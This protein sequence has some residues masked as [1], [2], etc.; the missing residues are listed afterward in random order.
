MRHAFRWCLGA[1][2]M[3]LGY[4]ASAQD[5]AALY[6]ASCAVCHDG[7]M[8]RAP[9]RDL[10]E[11]MLPEQ[12]LHAL[13]AGSMISMAV[14]MSS[15]QRRAVAEYLTGKPFDSSLRMT[16]TGAA[17][18]GSEAAE[19]RAGGPTWMGWGG[20]S[21]ANTR[22][23]TAAGAGLRAADVPRLKLKWAFGLPGHIQ[24]YGNPAVTGGRVFLGSQGG[25]VYSLDAET[26]CV[27]WYRNEGAS[28]RTGITV[29]EIELPDG[30][31]DVL[32]YGDQGAV[33]YAVDAATGEEIWR[34]EVDANPVARIT[35]SPVLHDG[36]L[37]VPLASNEEAAGANAEYQCCR[38]RG[39][40]VALDAATGKQIWKTYTVAEPKPTK[41][42]AIGTQLWGPSGVPIWSSPAID[43]VLGR[44]YVTTGN[45]YTDPTS[46]LS[47][48]FVAMDIDSGRILWHRQMTANDAYVAACRLE[49]KTNCADSNGPDVDFGASPILVDL[50]DGR[51][52]LV[53]GQ[54]SGVVHALDP[55]DDGAV[56]WQ[57]RIGRGG[58]MGGIQWGSA[59]DAE[60]V[61]VALSDIERIPVQ[62]SWATE[63]DPE[64]GGG[65]FA[66]RLADGE[67]VWYTPPGRCGER[68]RCSP[69]QSAAVTAIPGV[70]FS[71]SVDGHLRA[72]SM[73]TGEIVWD[74]DTVRSYETVNG[75]PG[76]GGSLDGAGPVIAGGMLFVNSGYPTGG[77]MP[78]NV[79]L[80]FGVDGQ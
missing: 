10:F 37:F 4:G 61:Y 19:F 57:Q 45:N 78:G 48:A 39:S 20:V 76:Q 49:D 46:E 44:V 52:V 21:T 11:A 56:I 65:M 26:G 58:S 16:P 31:R 12:I 30:P 60:N 53:A 72:Y 25:I 24:S 18:C 73:E 67:R 47:D 3:T 32:F 69:A 23:Q 43:P 77:G 80:A 63:A 27:H 59:A 54:K 17:M 9:T 70:A 38:F 15:E 33:A 75:V 34:V 74:Y 8:N 68:L 50:G 41:K 62:H 36:R 2:L 35:G 7:G 6:D 51:R 71:G 64:I 5:G 79:F 42:N 1:V 29:A 28:V 40:L 14:T 22:F 55:D 13:E 66:L